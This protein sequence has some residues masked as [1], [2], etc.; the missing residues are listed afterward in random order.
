[1]V[2]RFSS[3]LHVA[4]LLDVSLCSNPSARRPLHP[5]PIRQRRRRRLPLLLLLLLLRYYYYRCC[6]AGLSNVINHRCLTRDNWGAGF[7]I[8]S[9]HMCPNMLARKEK[10]GT[11]STCNPHVGTTPLCTMCLLVCF[12]ATHGQI[13][14]RGTC[15]FA[16]LI[17]N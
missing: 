15:N 6:N 3:I 17:R 13:L 1:M 12:S 9:S 7:R 14:H 16:K 8:G 5:P 2:L 4:H 11:N 10:E